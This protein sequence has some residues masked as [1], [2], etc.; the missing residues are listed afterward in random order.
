MRTVGIIQP[1]YIPWRG[2]FDF[3]RKVDVF[4]FLDDVQYTRQDWRNRNIIRTLDGR[5]QYLTVPVEGGINQKIMDV[6]VKN[7]EPWKKKHLGS[8]KQNYRKAAYFDRYFPE[9]TDALMEDYEL[10]ADLDIALTRLVAGW[11]GIS[12]EFRLASEFGREGVKDEKLIDLVRAV[13]GSRY[14]SG[15]AA[16][17]YLRPELWQEADIELAFM[18]YGPYPDYPQIS[19]PFEPAVSVLD[20]V[21]MTGPNAPAH[22]WS[23]E[24]GIRS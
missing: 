23:N 22:I 13:D 20:L 14:L 8:L 10:L 17:A 16:T 1:N 18:T 3:I 15:P 11:L 9:F 19:Q 24:D 6:R 7:T 2:Y 12:T 21:F 4:I 5:T